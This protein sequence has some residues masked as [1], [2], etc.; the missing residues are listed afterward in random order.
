MRRLL[1]RRLARTATFLYALILRFY[2]PAFR[3]RCGRAMLDTFEQLCASHVQRA[4]LTAFLR[5]W[6]AET[7]D[8]I[9]AVRRS[10]RVERSLSPMTNRSAL[11]TSVGAIVQDGVH[12][13]KRLRAQPTIVVFTALTLGFA[14]AATAAIFSIADAVMLRPSPFS[15]PERLVSVSNR[16]RSGVSFPGLSR[17]KLRQWRAQQDIFEAVEGY[18]RSRVVITGG[19]EPE[20]VPAAYIS[21]G[22]VQTLGVPAR[23]GRTFHATEGTPGQEAAL[24]VSDRYW[25]TRLGADPQAVGRTISVN[26]QPH[27]I[28]GV[29][30]DRFRFPSLREAVWLPQDLESG[31]SARAGVIEILAR[32]RMGLTI[33]T[34]QERIDAVAQALASEQPLPTGW[35]IVVRP[36]PVSGPSDTTRRTVMVL[37]GAVALVLLSACANVANLLLSRGVDRHRQLTIRLVLGASRGRLFRELLIEGLVLGLASGAVGLTAAN[38]AL[39][40][41]VRVAPDDLVQATNV[42]IAMDVRVAAF[43]LAL[44][45]VT[46]TLCNVAPALR[47]TK[48]TG[49]HALTGRTKAAV[50]SP[51]QRHLRAGLVVAEV[52]LAVV[53]LIGA[54][55][56]TRTFIQ[57][58]GIDAGFDPDNVLTVAVGLD[59][60]RY[61]DEAARV[62]FLKPLAQ[63]LSEIPGV[64][65]VAISAGVPSEPGLRGGAIPET[66][67]GRCIGDDWTAVVANVVSPTYFGLM[68][69]R[70]LHGRPLREDDAPTAVV[71][72]RSLAQLCGGEALIGKRL[73][74]GDGAPWLDVVGIAADV[75]NQSLTSD[76]GAVA[77]YAPLGVDPNGLLPMLATLHERRVVSRRLLVRADD[78]MAVADTVKRLLWSRDRDQPVLD[79]TPASELMGETIRR[80]R[81]MLTLMTFF[82]AVSLALASAGIFGALA[83]TVS[84]RTNEIGV[85]MALG[86]SSSHV[87]RL[88]V[89]HGLRLAA[90]GIVLG[91]TGAFAV[92][93]VLAGLL[94]EVD[95]RDPAAFMSI[96][97]LVLIVALLA[98]CIPTTRALRVDPASALRVE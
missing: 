38:W 6:W 20:E 29:M 10:H 88:V 37:F 21:P 69:M 85:R 14:I 68:G 36:D 63:D 79:V 23:L 98:S 31:G 16:S 59:T 93:R 73:R 7:F 49:T 67:A 13:V 2:P 12:A 35:E 82:S 62:N 9:R 43:T 86:A 94:Y 50:E 90:V 81:F 42:A 39:E 58:N 22:L 72:S 26:G 75:K 1:L 52:A 55:L 83:Y 30:P 44:S 28:V 60:G 92:S 95:P 80:E 61:A 15:Q 89:G 70:I 65:G 84:Q 53:L 47:A 48:A 11:D 33:R 17:E 4:S 76:E 91:V 97:L 77:L 19:V 45:I 41:L 24:L 27:L 32:I 5:I 96:P 87:L 46:G 66:E 54:A 18:R 64:T 25:R 8:A 74:L 78:P 51:L 40:T 34:A 57:L 3:E 56:M 71:I